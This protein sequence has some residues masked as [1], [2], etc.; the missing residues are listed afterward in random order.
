[1]YSSCEAQNVQCDVPPQRAPLPAVTGCVGGGDG[2]G[3]CE[4]VFSQ[5]HFFLEVHLLNYYAIWTLKP[6]Y[7]YLAVTEGKRCTWM[8]V[9]AEY[10]QTPLRGMG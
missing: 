3:D 4:R 8:T 7:F 10:I 6:P 9:K 5:W 2:Q 1:M